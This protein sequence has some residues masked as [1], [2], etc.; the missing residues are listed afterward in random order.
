MGKINFEIDLL[1]RGPF[2]YRSKTFALGRGNTPGT[3]SVTTVYTVNRLI[4]PG[5][6]QCVGKRLH[7]FGIDG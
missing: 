5:G 3:I 6:S 7:Y 4:T 1:D 2:S